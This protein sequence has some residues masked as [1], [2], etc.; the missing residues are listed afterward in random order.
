MSEQLRPYVRRIMQEKGLTIMEVAEGSGGDMSPELLDDIRQG[1]VK[2]LSDSQV[3]ALA[4][5]LGQSEDD[6]RAVLVTPS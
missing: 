3:K 1:D 6:V 5:G 2:D 4:S